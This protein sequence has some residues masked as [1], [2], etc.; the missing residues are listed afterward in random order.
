MRRREF[1]AGGVAAAWPLAA[2][3]Q[4]AKL[5]TIGVLG[6][7]TPSA[8]TDWN[9]AFVRRLGDSA[10]ARDARLPSS[11]VGRKGATSAIT[12]SQP[13]L[14]GS[15]SMSSSRWEARSLPRG[16]PHR[17][18]PSFSRLLS[19]RL[20]AG[21]SRHWRGPAATSPACQCRRRNWPPSGSNYCA[22]CCPVFASWRSS[23]ISTTPPRWWR[24][25]RYCRRPHVWRRPRPA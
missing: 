1:I 24:W 2:H 13:S 10:G 6:A 25:A 15:R 20:G 8:W 22:R 7:G 12:K 4:Q 14:S 11:I 18:F 17:S 19:T 23:A 21:W 9:A 3:G 16:R 5:P